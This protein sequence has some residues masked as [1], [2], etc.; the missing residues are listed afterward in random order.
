MAYA[1]TVWA[2]DDPCYR[3]IG[4]AGRPLENFVHRVFA[5]IADL[6]LEE[7]SIE[8]SLGQRIRTFHFDRILCGHH[9]E[10]LFQ[11]VRSMLSDIQKK[12]FLV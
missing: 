7:E 10:W 8:L 9:E 11:R 6:Q 5:R 12:R 3:T 2:V 4:H 1:W